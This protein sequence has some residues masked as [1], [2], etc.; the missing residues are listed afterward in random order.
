MISSRVRDLHQGIPIRGA[1]PDAERELASVPAEF[2][3]PLSPKSVDVDLSPGET[4]RR[5]VI[6]SLAL[7][8]PEHETHQ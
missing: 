6:D 1:L 2:P 8:A 5:R 7:V 3:V 4:R